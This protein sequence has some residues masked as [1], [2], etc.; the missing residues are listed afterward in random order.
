MSAV[1]A[2]RLAYAASFDHSSPEPRPNAFKCKA[3]EALEAE[4][5]DFILLLIFRFP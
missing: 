4:Q 3:R 1:K 5:S 2:S